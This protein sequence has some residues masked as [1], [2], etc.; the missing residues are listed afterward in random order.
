MTLLFSLLKI[1]SY[2]PTLFWSQRRFWRYQ[3]I[4]EGQ[5]TK[6]LKVT[7]KD[8]KRS[9]KHYSENYRSGNMNLTKNWGCRGSVSFSCSSNDI[10]RVPYQI[11]MTYFFSTG[12]MAHMSVRIIYYFVVAYRCQNMTAPLTNKMASNKAS[13]WKCSLTSQ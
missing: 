8:K 12:H 6:W 11:L 7:K 9:T 2:I 1:F 3:K 10:R 4:E 13:E 5:T